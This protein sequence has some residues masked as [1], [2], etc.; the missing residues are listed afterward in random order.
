MKTKKKGFTLIELLVVIAIIG[1]LATVV[2]LNIGNAKLKTQDAKAKSDVGTAYRAGLM[3]QSNGGSL[4]NLRDYD[5]SGV[6][7]DNY[8]LDNA[9]VAQFTDGSGGTILAKAP[10]SPFK[11][12]YGAEYTYCVN[13]NCFFD[14]TDQLYIDSLLSGAFTG[15]GD[16]L[17]YC[18]LNY[19]NGSG[20]GGCFLQNW[21]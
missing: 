19:D 1:I 12:Q 4:R 10:V 13:T 6:L 17:Y 20:M 21:N 7:Y 3:F 9:D 18:S 5:A 8:V 14:D 2:I 16:T 11:V 15:I